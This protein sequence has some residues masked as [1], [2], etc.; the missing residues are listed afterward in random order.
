MRENATYLDR[1][2]KLFFFKIAFETIS[3]RQQTIWEQFLMTR[4]SAEV[5]PIK[6]F[7]FANE[8]FLRFSLIS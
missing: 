4:N 8:E 1:Q 7:F 5:D 2:K 3:T 6:L